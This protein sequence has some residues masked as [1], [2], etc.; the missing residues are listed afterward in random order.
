[1]WR[2]QP[3]DFV[4]SV[5]VSYGRYNK[6]PHIQ[7][8]KTTQLNSLTV[9]EVRSLKQVLRGSNQGVSRT[10]F[11]SLGENLSLAFSGL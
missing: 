6:G 9:L 7:W 10:A 8:L 1:M 11:R 5:L 4:L 2:K 3:L